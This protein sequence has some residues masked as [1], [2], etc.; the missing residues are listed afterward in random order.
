MSKKRRKKTRPPSPSQRL[1]S[2]PSV[3][4]KGFRQWL[5]FLSPTGGVCAGIAFLLTLLGTYYTFSPKISVET[6]ETANASNPFATPFL[7][8]NDSLLGVYAIRLRTSIRNLQAKGSGDEMNECGTGT[9][10]PPI[11]KLDSGESTSFFVS[12][13]FRMTSPVTRADVEIMVSYRP[14]LL[15]SAR[16]RRFR[17]TTVQTKDGNLHW[18]PKAV[19]EHLP[20]TSLRP[21]PQQHTAPLPTHSH[22]G[23]TQ[24]PHP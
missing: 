1:A 12:F 3:E 13:P 7:I 22:V 14:A 5:G 2:P 10:V 20:F 21:Q 23:D 11:P 17:F 15:L 24:P 18:V 8:R 16:S 4:C 6:G 19:A 9:D